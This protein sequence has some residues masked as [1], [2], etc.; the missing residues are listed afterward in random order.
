MPKVSVFLNVKEVNNPSSIELDDFLVMTKDGTWED[1]VTR[2]RVEKS[3]DRRDEMKR[4]LPTVTMSGEFSSRNEQGMIKH[5]GYICMDLDDVDDIEKTQQLLE[6]DR[7]V[8]AIW[9]S[10]SGNGLRVML[11]IDPKKHRESFYGICQYF[12]ERYQIICD[13]NGV[14]LSKPYVVSWDPNLYI[15]QSQEIPIFKKYIK[16]TPIKKINDFVHTDGDFE[17]VLNQITSRG[18]IICEDY[19]DWLKVC[20]AI[21]E[22][23]GERGRN[24]FHEVSRQHPKYDFRDTEKQYTACLKARGTTKANIST[25][26]YLAKINNV[27]I[28]SEQT[29][30]IVRATKNGKKAGLNKDQIIKNLLEFSNIANADSLV[31][32]VYNEGTDDDGE[33]QSILF[34]LEMYI[35]NNYDLRMNEVTGYLEKKNGGQ[36][37]P[38]DLNSLFISSKKVIPKVDYQLMMRLLKSDFIPTYNPFFEFFKSDGVPVELPAIP[39]ENGNTYESPIIDT[40]AR[41]IKNDD[42][43]YTN[44][45]LKKWI[46]SIVS[47]AHKVHSPLVFCLLGSQN[48]GKTEFFR[49]LFPKELMNYY[50]ESKLDKEK[51][52]ELLM[53]EN[54]IIMDDELGGKSKQ[55]AQKLKN[56][57]SKQ[58]FSLRRPYGDHNEKILRL[59]VLCGTSNYHEVLSDSTGNRRIIPIEV[60]DVNKELYNSID[61]KELF[62]EAFDIYKKGFDW[63][64]T[65]KDVEYLN[66]DQSKYEMVIKERELIE[67]YFKPGDRSYLSTTDILV[68]IEMITK[69]RLGLNTVGREL[70]KLGFEKRTVRDD[71][72]RTPKKWGV[73]RINRPTQV[74]NGNNQVF[75]GSKTNSDDVPF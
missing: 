2:V 18:I 13:P 1:A 61:K 41:T 37:T 62:M 50:A 28:A 22:H 15:N 6:N 54:L 36:L 57:T 4:A 11:I 42:P 34:Q 23:F 10:T 48:T 67:K 25:F 58:Y 52:D 51:D 73:E 66:K 44:Y 47:S 53:T 65:H 20:F 69:Q 49:R 33:E 43:A 39:V 71:I 64:I 27:N 55:D 8:Y 35:S 29:K 56:I 24:Y 72:G 12:H 16:E 32:K 19:N 59:A 74:D 63:R 45:F 26:Y 17:M 46:V 7:Y 68:E 70:L 21:S 5:S 38:S 30:A 3:K 31:E 75:G 9:V 14:S 40:L 60:F